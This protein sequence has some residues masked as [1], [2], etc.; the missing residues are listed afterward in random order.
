MNDL[1]RPLTQGGPSRPPENL[2]G[3]LRRF[4]RSEMPRSWPA[5]PKVETPAARKLRPS[6]PWFRPSSRL[7]LAA[8]VAL[9]LIGYLALAGKFP[10]DQ[11]LRRH[12][13]DSTNP[14]ATDPL[15]LRGLGLLPLE[16]QTRRLSDG[17]EAKSWGVRTGPNGT[18]YLNVE[19][20]R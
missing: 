5:A 20:T 9:L 2:D 3:L 7:A 4:F 16:P 12:S 17:G 13:I 14:T 18:I 15:K 19:R 11:S 10:T 6:R 1:R 8:A